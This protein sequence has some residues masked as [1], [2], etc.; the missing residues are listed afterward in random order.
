MPR[1]AMGRRR[2]GV[3]RLTSAVVCPSAVELMRL[4]GGRIEFEIA[5]SLARGPRCVSAVSRE[6]GWSMSQVSEA[7]RAMKEHGLLEVTR[8]RKFRYYRHSESVLSHVEGKW[9]ELAAMCSNGDRVLVQAHVG[10]GGR[11]K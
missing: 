9:M 11:G 5:A 8:E 3:R 2:T 4:L 6:L 1:Y 10:K 7:L